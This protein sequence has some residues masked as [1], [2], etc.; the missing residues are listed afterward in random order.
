V[1][2]ERNL[3][4]KGVQPAIHIGEGGYEGMGE[5][6]RDCDHKL[7]LVHEKS[8]MLISKNHSLIADKLDVLDISNSKKLMFVREKVKV[9]LV[10]GTDYYLFSF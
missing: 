8:N 1:F 10:K 9:L 7:I 3:I 2:S 6:G 4:E 5:R